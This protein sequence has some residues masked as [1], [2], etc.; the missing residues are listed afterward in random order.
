[1]APMSTTAVPAPV[2]LHPLS[3]LT[4]EEIKAARQI[5]FDSGRSTVGND[6]LRFAY[7]A[8]CDPP[9]DVVRAVDRGE[10]GAACQDRSAGA[11]GPSGGPRGRRGRSRGLG[12]P[13]RGRALGGGGGR[14]PAA[15]DGGG[16]RDDPRSGRVRGVE[17]CARPPGHRGP[18]ARPGRPLAGGDVRSRPREAAPDHQVPGVPARVAR[19]QRLRAPDRGAAGHRRHGPGRGARGARLRRL[20]R[21]RRPRAATTP[22]TTGRCAPT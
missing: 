22:S 8:L 15:P 14:P 20:S 17:R 3:P 6:A 18:F 9:K 21:S 7:L 4:G 2:S 13:R 10:P 11:D 5:V 1:M 16:V 12:H 19:R